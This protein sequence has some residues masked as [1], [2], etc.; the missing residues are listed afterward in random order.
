MAKNMVFR[1]RLEGVLRDDGWRLIMGKVEGSE[2]GD[3]WEHTQRTKYFD[4]FDPRARYTYEAC[5]VSERMA[6]P[7]PSFG[8]G[9]GGMFLDKNGESLKGDQSYVMRVEADAP[10]ELFWAIT[11]Y[12]TDTRGL[13]NTSQQKAEIG[14]AHGTTQ[15]NE[16]GSTY[17]FVGPEAPKGW[18][19]NWVKSVPGQ[20]WFPYLRL[21]FP[22]APYFDQSWPMPAIEPVD[23]VDYAK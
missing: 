5:T 17:V 19:S 6:F 14:S 10:A 7:K 18:E 13:M 22:T 21:Y 8:M 11:V 16:D 2:P 4:R 15:V 12:D 20:G 3:A 9:Y 23:F 1:E